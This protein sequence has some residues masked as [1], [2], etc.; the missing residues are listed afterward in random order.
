MLGKIYSEYMTDD[1]QRHSPTMPDHARHSPTAAERVRPYP[2][3]SAGRREDHTMT[4]TEVVKLF[5]QTNLPRS[6]RSIERYCTAGKLDCFFDEDEQ[7]YYVTQASA[8]RLIGQLQEIQARHANATFVGP[9]Q[10]AGARVRQDPA[11]VTDERPEHSTKMKELEDKVFN[12]EIDRRAKEQ[13]INQLKDQIKV[14][15]QEFV[16]QLVEHSR[17]V[18]QLETKLLQLEGSKGEEPHTIYT[19]T[20]PQASSTHDIPQYEASEDIET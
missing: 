4:S 20:K 7:R 14:D 9:S 15:R 16:Q 8:E 1:I 11:P 5:E 18:G 13:V 10:T 17:R 19:D 2:T 6:Q 12:L 3:L